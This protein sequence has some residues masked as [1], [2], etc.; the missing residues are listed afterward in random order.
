MRALS[1]GDLAA[2]FS[3]RLAN[4]TM[5]DQIERLS[6]EMTTGRRDADSVLRS[7]DV[8][9]MAGLDR[10]LSVLGAYTITTKET[11][12][13]VGVAQ[14]ALGAVSD[15]ASDLSTLLLTAAAGGDPAYLGAV[16]EEAAQRFDSMVGALNTTIAGQ[17]VFAGA[18]TD[19]TPLADSGAILTALMADVGG[20]PTAGDLNDAVDAWF[21]PGGGFDT[22]AYLG[23]DIARAPVSVSDSERVEFGIRADN[24]DLRQVLADTAKAAL[25]DRGALA[26]SQV[27]RVSLMNIAGEALLNSGNAVTRLRGELGVTEHRLE[28]VTTRQNAEKTALQMARNDLVG[29]DPYDAA[30]KLQDVQVQLETLYTVTARMSK[31]SLANYL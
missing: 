4:R 21:A 9:P 23:A 5:K 8:G 31:L 17:S 2:S 25:L 29:V 20:A 15:R 6:T 16:S 19:T 18:A 27:A 14:G 11:A 7:G 22:A 3:S 13:L 24:A 26:G 1:I 28:Q 10:S 12:M 30:T